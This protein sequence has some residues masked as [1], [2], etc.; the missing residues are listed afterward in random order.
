MVRVGHA[1]ALD[2]VNAILVG[3]G[4][5]HC[6]AP[7]EIGLIAGSVPPGTMDS[8]HAV[9]P[10]YIMVIVVGGKGLP[11]VVTQRLLAGRGWEAH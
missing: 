6:I 2:P 10:T 3:S 8:H 11:I 1:E 4:L 9:A 5:V 7:I